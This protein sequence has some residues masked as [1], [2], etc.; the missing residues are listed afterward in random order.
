MN[1]KLV[2]AVIRQLGGRDSLEDIVNHGIDG[3]YTGF[4]YYS[5]TVKFFKRNRKQIIELVKEMAEEFGQNPMEFVA[6]FNCLK[7]AG[8][9]EQEIG[10][11]LYGRIPADSVTVPNALA[12]FAAEE[13]ARY[14]ID[15]M[16]EESK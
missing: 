10:Q 4:F 9:Y 3:G 2:N 6:S 15:R 7:P 8:E 12:W 5:D 1:K 13:V 16:E 11:A 14:E